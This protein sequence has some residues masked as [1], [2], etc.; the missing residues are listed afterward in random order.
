M[1]AD[2]CQ[3]VLYE[4]TI[5]RMERLSMAFGKVFNRCDE[6]TLFAFVL[7]QT[8]LYAVTITT[9]EL[10]SIPISDLYSFGTTLIQWSI[11]CG[12]HLI[13]FAL[14]KGIASFGLH[15]A[16]EQRTHGVIRGIIFSIV[17]LLCCTPL[18]I[19]IS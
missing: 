5:I 18:I 9:C 14:I 15:V 2:G 3:V 4:S 16:S 7:I 11:I 17:T 10:H 8:L 19:F 13:I 12:F 1:I 6:I